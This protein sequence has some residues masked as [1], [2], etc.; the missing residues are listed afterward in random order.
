MRHKCYQID[1]FAS[2]YF[3]EETSLIIKDANDE[4]IDKI[5]K[6]GEFSRKIKYQTRIKLNDNFFQKPPLY[7]LKFRKGKIYYQKLDYQYKK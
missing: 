4:P 7:K 6:Y 1:D 3:E 2:R 5:L